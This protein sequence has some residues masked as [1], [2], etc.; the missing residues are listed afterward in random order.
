MAHRSRLAGFI[1]DCHIDDLAAAVDFWSQALGVPMAEHEIEEGGRNTPPSKA[2]LRD[3]HVEVQKVEHPSRVHLDIEADDIDAEV[4]RLEALGAK[5]IGCV[6]ALVGDG[7]ADRAALL[8]REDAQSREG[9]DAERLVI[10]ARSAASARRV[11]GDDAIA[12]DLLR[13]I[14]RLVRA[15]EHRLGRYRAP[16]SPSAMPIDTVTATATSSC[17]TCGG[18]VRRFPRRRPARVGQHDQELFAAVTHGD[19]G[20]AHRARDRIGHRAQRAIAEQVSVA[21]VD[22][23]EVIDVEHGSTYGLLGECALHV[24]FARAGARGPRG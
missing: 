1:I 15:F 5:R 11:V 10:G 23:L 24:R 4:A 2:R 18:C 17:S 8:R 22:L 12:S 19:V 21:I 3:L 9:P 13:A 14:E 20:R 16:A 7:S 6:Q